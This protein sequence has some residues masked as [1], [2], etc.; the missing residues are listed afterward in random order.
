MAAPFEH[1]FEEVEEHLDE[2]DELD[3]SAGI[4]PP[5]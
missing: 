1:S 4:S 2:T 5:S 3:A